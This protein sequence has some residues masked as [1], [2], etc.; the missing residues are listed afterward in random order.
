MTTVSVILFDLGRVLV[1]ID[2]EAFPRMLGIQRNRV[3][4]ADEAAIEKIA[5]QYETGRITTEQFFGLLDEAL[6]HKFTRPQLLAAWNAIIEEENSVIGPIIDGVQARYRTAILSNTSPTHFQKAIDTSPIIRKFS[7]W[8]L[9]YEIGVMK[10]DAGVYKY[11]IDDL[12]TDPSAILFIDDI[13]LNIA[14]A[15][16]CGMQGIVF[17]GISQLKSE[18]RL[19]G[20]L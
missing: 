20:I 9:S 16:K 1:H 6:H 5:I 15:R 11:V 18:L 14:A 3:N 19:R 2:F 12:K 8:Y 17:E 13:P 10:P 4:N 7:K